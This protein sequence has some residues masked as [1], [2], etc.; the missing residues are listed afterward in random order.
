MV[1]GGNSNIKKQ[2]IKNP[3]QNETYLE[4]VCYSYSEVDQCLST[5]VS[6]LH[7][8]GGIIL[9]QL[10]NLQAWQKGKEKDT[11]FSVVV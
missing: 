6:E 4:T 11:G 2:G 8:T 7:G 3:W 1:G 10:P 5:P 9:I